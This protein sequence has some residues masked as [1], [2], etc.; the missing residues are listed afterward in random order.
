[1]SDG[2]SDR[3]ESAT[4]YVL[5]AM[6]GSDDAF[7]ELVRLHQGK[8]IVLLT[9]VCGGRAAAEDVAQAAFLKAWR[10][11]RGLRDAALF[12]PWLRQIA[13]R[14]AIDA[15]R[16]SGERVEQG[17]GIAEHAATHAD[18]RLDLEAALRKLT[19]AQRACVL[20]S[21][22]E[23]LS[24]SEIASEL[25]MPAGTVKSHVARGARLLRELLSDW[26]R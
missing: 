20:L 16:R 24:H 12:G 23:G 13:M 22:G 2:S 3:E 6:A 10:N 9:R 14:A 8:L 11:I 25:G 17:E 4:T 1:M 26:E 15:A 18:A 5:L 21:Y 19:T 7:G